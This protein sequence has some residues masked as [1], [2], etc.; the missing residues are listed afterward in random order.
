MDELVYFG[1]DNPIVRQLYSGADLVGDLSPVTRVVL[2]L[3]NQT[4]AITIDSDTTPAVFDWTTLGQSKIELRLGAHN[5]LIAAGEKKYNAY[6]IVF[7]VDNTDGV[8][9]KPFQLRTIT[10]KV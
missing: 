9:Y 1:R 8:E 5:S 2:V 3:E 7:D 10:A 4:T 6:L